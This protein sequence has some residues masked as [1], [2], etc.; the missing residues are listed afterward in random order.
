M[1]D[2]NEILVEVKVHLATID[3]HRK[4]LSHLS[5]SLEDIW[6]AVEKDQNMIRKVIDYI[7][8]YL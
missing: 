8:E 5:D 4:E 1:K 6:N 7:K 2:I 3:R